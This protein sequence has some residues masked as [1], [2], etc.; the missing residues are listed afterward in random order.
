VAVSNG[1]ERKRTGKA[2]NEK[3]VAHNSKRYALFI[4]PFIQP[5]NLQRTLDNQVVIEQPVFAFARIG[6]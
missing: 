5:E 1:N 6:G 3:G 2:E 4:F